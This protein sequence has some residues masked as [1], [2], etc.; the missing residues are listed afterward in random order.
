MQTE[1]DADCFICRKHRGEIHIPGGAIAEDDLVYAGHAQIRPGQTTAYL[2]YLMAEPKRHVTGLQFLSDDEARALGLWVARLSR[3]LV[4]VERADHVYAFVLGDQVA[5]V[6]VHVVAR[7]PGAPTEYRG[8]RVDEWPE[9]PRGGPS[10]IE[11]LCE[12]LRQ[13]LRSD[14]AAVGPGR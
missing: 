1:T 5:H 11:A 6:H 3:A 14:A 13:W 9:A 4:A 7:Y 8:P 10:E 12:R 2:G